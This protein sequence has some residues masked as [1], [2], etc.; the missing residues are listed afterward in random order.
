MNTQQIQIIIFLLLSTITSLSTAATA[1]HAEIDPDQSSGNSGFYWE[2]SFQLSG[3]IKI[4]VDNS[5]IHFQNIDII[6]NPSYNIND[7]ILNNIA[8][9][10]GYNFNYTFC[11]T[12]IGN[13][14][15]GTFDG[16]SL[17][18]AGVTYG[19]EPIEYTILSSNI[20]NVPLPGGLVLFISGLAAFI[21]GRLIKS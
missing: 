17:Y 14:Y 11:D 12:C 1:Y 3:T 13:G 16:M 19:L 2:N 21:S 18:L 9:Y 7:M 20:S 6:S 4:T 10:D 8:T 15:W 5:T